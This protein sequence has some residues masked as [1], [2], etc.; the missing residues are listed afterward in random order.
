[1]EGIVLKATCRSVAV[2]Q[3]LPQNLYCIREVVTRLVLGTADVC[4]VQQDARQ[5]KQSFHR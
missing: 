1:M 4:V 5:D 3:E 2:R